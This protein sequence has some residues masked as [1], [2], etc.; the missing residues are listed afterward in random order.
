MLIDDSK[1]SF[2]QEKV[3]WILGIPLMSMIPIIW[4]VRCANT[5]WRL[6]NFVLFGIVMLITLIPFYDEGGWNRIKTLIFPLLFFIVAI[7][8]PLATDLQLTQWFQSKISLI[9]VDILLLL[10]H[11]ASLQGTVID[12]GVFGQVGIDQACSGI[13]GLQASLVVTLFFGSYYRFKFFN[14]FILFFL[15]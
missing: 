2:F 7:P 8:W 14:R 1:P 11:E 10:E 4:V 13:N 5:D 6:L 15:D 3:W 12:V 9:I